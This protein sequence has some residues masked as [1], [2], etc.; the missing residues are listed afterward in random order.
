[1]ARELCTLA[2][3][4]ALVPG[5]VTDTDTDALLNV[6]ITSESRTAH[7]VAGREFVAL[8]GNTTRTFD[9][10]E[11]IVRK[12][13]LP[14][15]DLRTLT[16]VTVKDYGGTTIQSN[17]SAV[18]LPRVRQEWEPITELFVPPSPATT[19]IEWSES[20]VLEITGTWGFPSIPVDVVQAVAKM[21]LVRYLAD[22]AGA[23]TA[24]ADA[25]NEQDFNAAVAFA[26]SQD[27]LRSYLPAT[28]A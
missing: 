7:E 8:T 14:V 3:V 6:L 4:T 15:G 13:I 17:P 28:F 11:R 27:V 1:M 23:G 9:L 19:P 5:Y 25:L 12:R 26:S 2:D 22:A 21:V 18:L 16:S 24:L 20:Y 10:D